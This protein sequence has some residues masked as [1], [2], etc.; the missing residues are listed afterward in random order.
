M[1]TAVFGACKSWLNL[2][3]QDVYYSI[4]RMEFARYN[5]VARIN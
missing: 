4:L 3:I 1:Q 2:R 5:G